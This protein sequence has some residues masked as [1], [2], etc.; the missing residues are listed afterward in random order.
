MRKFG[1]LLT[2]MA[3]AIIALPNTVTNDVVVATSDAELRISDRGLGLGLE[4]IGGGAAEVKLETRPGWRFRDGSTSVTLNKAAGSSAKSPAVVGEGQGAE[5]YVPGVDVNDDESDGDENEEGSVDHEKAVLSLTATAPKVVAYSVL[6]G[7]TNVSITLS[8]TVTTKGKHRK[9]DANGNVVKEEEFSPK[10]YV[11]K[12]TGAAT[13]EAET[14]SS[15]HTFVASL[16]KGKDKKLNF[17]VV[18]KICGICDGEVESDKATDSVEIDVYELSISR[19]DYLGL[20]RTDAGR[21]GH[22]VKTATLSSDPSLPSSSSVEW[23]ECGICEFV[24][25]KNQRSVSYQNKDSD[26]A[27]GEYL[28]ERLAASVRLAGMNSSVVCATNFTVVKVDAQIAG[29]G[30]LL[31]ETRGPLIPNSYA[32]IKKESPVAS[33]KKELVIT[34]KPTI[35]V[36]NSVKVVPSGVVLL[37]V[38]KEF[39]LYGFKSPMIFNTKGAKSLSFD[40]WGNSVDL[41]ANANSVKVMHL[42]SQY[43]QDGAKDLVKMT[44]YGFELI[45]PAGD[46]VKEANSNDGA[47]G[48]NEFTYNDARELDGRKGVLRVWVKARIL[49]K[50]VSVGEN[51]IKGKFEVGAI[52]GSSLTWRKKQGSGCNVYAD[53]SVEA[54]QNGVFEAAALFAGYPEQNSAFGKKKA[55]FTLDGVVKEADYEVFFPKYGISHPACGLCPGCP[56]WFYY[57][58]NGDVCN[59]P[60]YVFYGGNESDMYGAAFVGVLSLLKDNP[61]L[62]PEVANVL[63]GI[64]DPNKLV[65]L[66][67]LAAEEEEEGE[68]ADVIIGKGKRAKKYLGF[69]YGGRRAGLACCAAIVAHEVHHVDLYNMN[70]DRPDTDKDQMADG[71]ESS[72]DGIATHVGRRD[73]YRLSRKNSNYGVYAGYGDNEIRARRVERTKVVYHKDR[74]W[75]NPGFQS[76]SKC[77]YDA[78]KGDN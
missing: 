78:L 6:N 10:R 26:T 2:V 45:T 32:D 30:E 77:G 64:V 1:I 33:K 55:R 16:T 53:G 36:D 75:A 13:G 62:D 25:A 21:Q 37:P 38:G 19:P 72:M 66:Y 67:D 27:S 73:T 60:D 8:A 71:F 51:R 48:Q 15:T 11:W 4:V 35:P 59:M 43:L 18:G 22:V 31:E 17:S 63:A 68:V 40:V 49:P 58:K 65:A 42:D 5:N 14:D 9:L 7:G 57:W 70:A 39:S 76:E 61:N 54:D 44:C 20:D 29:V 52:E 3:A 28:A 23:T 24:G 34:I 12:M 69:K 56:N 47:D 46:P 50:G 41:A 74:D